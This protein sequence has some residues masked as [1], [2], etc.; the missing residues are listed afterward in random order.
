MTH[1]GQLFLRDR[2]VPTSKFHA[3]GKFGR[4][5][6]T[7]AP[8][9]SDTAAVRESLRELGKPGGIMDAQDQLFPAD[10]LAPNPNNPDNPN[11][12]AGFTFLGQFLD[13]DV[14]LDLTSSFER[15]LDPEAVENF[16]TPAFELD[17]V[18]GR[19]AG[20]VPT[21]TTE[22]HR[23]QS[24]WYLMWMRPGTFP[25]TARMSRLL[26]IRGTMKTSL[27]RNCI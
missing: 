14:T 18:M 19:D 17:S 2:A 11:M 24:R 6:P 1:H 13:H 26:V 10:P 20:Q 22:D 15:Q 9:A 21:C 8:F 25:G 16:R 23:L 3:R 27:C 7:L 4:L 5:F 12:T